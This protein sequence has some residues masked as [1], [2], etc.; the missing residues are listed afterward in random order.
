MPIERTLAWKRGNGTCYY[1]SVPLTPHTATRDHVHPR[2]RG[3]VN[4]QVRNIVLAC[5]PCNLHKGSQPIWVFLRSEWLRKRRAKVAKG[6][7]KNV[8]LSKD[9]EER[10][11]R[12]R[13]GLE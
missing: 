10:R 2:S 5:R 9:A 3:G 4:H 6:L 11:E 8:R 1:C 13:I 7:G 12:I